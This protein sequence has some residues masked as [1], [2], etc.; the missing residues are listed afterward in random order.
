MLSGGW[1]HGDMLAVFFA[2]AAEW[3]QNV[4][5]CQ[6]GK[7]GK[8]GFDYYGVKLHITGVLSTGY[9]IRSPAMTL[10]G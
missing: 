1:M 10:G 7:Q 8:D 5:W 9:C 6:N 2:K 3:R 4:C